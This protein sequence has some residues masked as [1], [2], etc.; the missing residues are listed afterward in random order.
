VD[1]DDLGSYIIEEE[2]SLSPLGLKVK[3]IE[4]YEYAFIITA[5]KVG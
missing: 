5:T 3:T 1:R 2:D 4:D